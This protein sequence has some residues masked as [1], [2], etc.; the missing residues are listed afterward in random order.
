MAVLTLEESLEFLHYLTDL[1]ELPDEEIDDVTCAHYR[2]R[3]DQNA[4]MDIA[5]Q[6][7]EDECGQVPEEYGYLLELSRRQAMDVEMWVDE[8]GYIRLLTVEW[9]GPIAGSGAGEETWASSRG[10]L[11]FYDFNESIIIEPPEIEA[12]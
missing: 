9:R 11:H 1:E 3:V 2:G 10:Y 5:E 7:Y 8:H 4:R 6:R 12:D